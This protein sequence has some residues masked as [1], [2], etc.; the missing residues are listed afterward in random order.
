MLDLKSGGPGFKSR[1]D[2]YLELFYGKP[3]I[4]SLA[5]LVNNNWSASWPSSNLDYHV[6]FSEYLSGVPVVPVN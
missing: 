1:T 5:K 3:W 6:V 2:H 4:S